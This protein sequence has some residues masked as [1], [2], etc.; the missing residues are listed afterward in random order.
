MSGSF[1]VT[2]SNLSILNIGGSKR[3]EVSEIQEMVQ[4]GLQVLVS[5]HKTTVSLNDRFG[6]SAGTMSW[7]PVNSS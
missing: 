2:I 5:A 3:S 6:N 7:T 4:R 1:S